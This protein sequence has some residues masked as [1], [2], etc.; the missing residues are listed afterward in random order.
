[1]VYTKRCDLV[2]PVGYKSH[3]CVIA[4]QLHG[5]FGAHMHDG[6]SK[7]STRVQVSVQLRS[8]LCLGGCLLL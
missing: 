7:R 3:V 8:M 6:D 5:A 2:C 4:I 1:M